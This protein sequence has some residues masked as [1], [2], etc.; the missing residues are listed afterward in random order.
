MPVTPRQRLV[1]IAL[2]A[3][4]FG[5][6]GW[7]VVFATGA[8]YNGKIGPAYNALGQDWL[9]FY[10][11][12]RAWHDGQAQLAYDQVWLAQTMNRTYAHWISNPM[13]YPGFHYPPTWLLI[14]APFSFLPM[15]AAY[16]ASQV[17]FFSGLLVALHKAYRERTQFW[18][19]SASLLLAPASSNNVLSGQNGFLVCGLFVAGFSLLETQPILAGAA[20]GLATFKPQICLMIPFALLGARNWRAIAGGLVSATGL[21]L[22]SLAVFGPGVWTTWLGL[23]LHPRHDV[24]YSSVDWGRLWDDSVFTCAQLLG[25]SKTAA[26]LCQA[27]AT[28]LAGACVYLSFR[29]PLSA[30]LRCA[31]FLAACVV[32]APHVSPYDM[33]LL[34]LAATIVAWNSFDEAFRPIA[35]AAPILGWLAP[36]YTPPRVSPVGLATPLVI[37]ALIAMVLLKPPRTA[38]AAEP[39]PAG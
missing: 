19:M 9:I 24:G 39:A 7:A 32:G 10:T 38:D 23:L 29:R 2:L 3:I 33:V 26:N 34:A 8:G 18:V 17:L 37:F 35:L 13:P 4:P 21:A 16:A 12:A 15:A 31:V 27:A 20:L 6:Y 25:A 30:D 36:I 28:L 11:A 14:L 5:L 22:L 1:R